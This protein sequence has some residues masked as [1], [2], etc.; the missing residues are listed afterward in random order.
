MLAL[1]VALAF[2]VSACGRSRASQ[3]INTTRTVNARTEVAARSPWSGVGLPQAKGSLPSQ[4]LEREGYV[5]S[6][7]SQTLNP[8]WVAWILTA[9]HTQGP[10]KRKGYSYVEDE[11]VD[12]R[13][14]YADWGEVTAE[15]Y[16]HGHMCPAGDNKW[17]AE[18]M[19]S[20]FLLTNMCP[21]N[22]RL[23]QE[24]WERLES[25]CRKWAQRL[26][27]IY[28]VCGPI[29]RNN[30]TSRLGNIAVPDAFYKVVLH[31]GENPRGVGFVYNNTDPEERENMANHVVPI[32]QIEE[33]TGI[34]FFPH[35]P[36][37]VAA[38]VKNVTSFNQWNKF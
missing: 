24:T 38:M 32:T 35:L 31:M 18:A 25:A 16:D 1:M 34:S 3:R 9:D 8:N 10:V 2:A 23:N 29:Y 17:S 19:Q 11:D 13:A 5:T 15:G 21:Q 36:S 26:G 27:T 6:Y 12:P 30:E 33:M 4:Q 20:T 37:D 14:T 7:N 22:R 28:I